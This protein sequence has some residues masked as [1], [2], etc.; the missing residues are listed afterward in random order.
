M[1]LP[2]TAPKANPRKVNNLSNLDRYITINEEGL[3]VFDGQV[4]HDVESGRTLLENLQPAETH[5]WTTSYQG[6]P[7]WVE[8][9][10]AL[11]VARHVSGLSAEEGEIDLPYEMKTRFRYDTLTID[12]WDR[13]H[14]VDL[15]GRDFV[16]S[17]SAQV[18]FF[19]L[20]DS[21]DDESVTI[22][23]R[24]HLTPSWLSVLGDTRKDTFWT[25]LYKGGQD[26]WEQGREALALP[27]VLPQLKLSKARILVLGCG[28]GHDA[29]F[30]ANQGH[31][32][33]GVDFSNEAIERAQTNYKSIENLSF[34]KAD[35]FSLPEQWAGRFDLI[36]EHTCYCAISPERRNELV[37]V[38][39]KMLQ[40]QGHLLGVFF[41]ME[42]RQGPP[43]G[44]SEWE[45]RERLKKDFNF[46]FW[47]RWHRSIPGR[48]S[49]ELVVY[50]SRKS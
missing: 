20:L 45:V 11:L 44:G 43:W 3:F 13:F 31:V 21:F 42:K 30:F 22:Q 4:L 47:T 35:I 26:N 28:S 27:D 34:V 2:Y 49:K 29:A 18:E 32:V 46:L 24:R 23:G 41:V 25:D 5:R 37:K 50:A 15:K 48:K 8:Y 19:E 39:K 40:P 6:Q 10:D 36:F 38:W 33:T 9:F 1:L 14:G 16:F 7:A 12:E 17:R